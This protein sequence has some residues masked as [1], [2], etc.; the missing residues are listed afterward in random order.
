V[1]VKVRENRFVFIGKNLDRP[2]LTEG[3]M[4]CKVGST[5]ILNPLKTG[6]RK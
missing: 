5:T 2:F 4:A 1:G 3:F 6:I